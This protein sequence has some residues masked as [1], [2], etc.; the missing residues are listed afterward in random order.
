MLHEQLRAQRQSAG[1]LERQLEGL[2]FAQREQSRILETECASKL[3][4]KD[5][6]ALERQARNGMLRICDTT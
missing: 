6:Q 5:I 2:L 1:L 3:H 4:E